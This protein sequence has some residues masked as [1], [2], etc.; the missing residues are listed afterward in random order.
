MPGKCTAVSPA[1]SG[2]AAAAPS[3]PRANSA[4]MEFCSGNEKKE[5]TRL[6]SFLL[7]RIR[8]LK[9]LSPAVGLNYPIDFSSFWFTRLVTSR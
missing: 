6:R 7:C 1:L 8:Y 5:W 4:G 9:A 2:N 3:P